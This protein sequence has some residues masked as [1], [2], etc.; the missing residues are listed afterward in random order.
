MCISGVDHSV[1]SLTSTLCPDTYRI[2][3][4][5]TAKEVKEQLEE[6]RGHLKELQGQ[7]QEQQK[8]AL[9]YENICRKLGLVSPMR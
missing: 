6:L 1:G 2:S 5:S 7:L 9:K 4:N 8:K 3:S